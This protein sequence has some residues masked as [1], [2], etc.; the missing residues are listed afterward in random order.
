MRRRRRAV[1]RTSSRSDD[2]LGSPYDTE[3]RASAQLRQRRI[4]LLPPVPHAHL[5][6]HGDRRGEVLA[7]LSTRPLVHS[8]TRSQAPAW[9]RREFA[10]PAASEWIAR[11]AK[12]N[13]IQGRA[14][15][16]VRSN[17][18]TLER[19]FSEVFSEMFNE[20]W[21]RCSLRSVKG[22]NLVLR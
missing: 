6:E 14:L 11:K 7:R 19:E 1:P 4:R 15:H 12:T 18:G 21:L 5:A 9:E 3:R 17:A 13:A 16:A 10:A 2:L 8:S 22:D 20:I